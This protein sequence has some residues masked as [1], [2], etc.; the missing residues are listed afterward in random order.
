MF[1]SLA[2]KVNDKHSAVVFCHEDVRLN[3][4]KFLSDLKDYKFSEVIMIF[5]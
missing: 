1:C 5:Y 3:L 4:E 2:V